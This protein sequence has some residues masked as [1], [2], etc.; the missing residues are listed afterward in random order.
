ML[1]REEV[2]AAGS[3]R[4]WG[5]LLGVGTWL[6]VLLAVGRAGL[7]FLIL[8]TVAFWNVGGCLGG[9]SRPGVTGRLSGI[10]VFGLTWWGDRQ[11]DTQVDDRHGQ[12]AALTRARTRGGQG[13]GTGVTQLTDVHTGGEGMSTE[14]TRMVGQH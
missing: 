14:A 2:M 12:G 8:T 10:R 9:R 3:V 13:T 4:A 11:T 5:W 6:A 7:G 1:L